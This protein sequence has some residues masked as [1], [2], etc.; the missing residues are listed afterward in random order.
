MRGAQSFSNTVADKQVAE[1]STGVDTGAGERAAAFGDSFDGNNSKLTDKSSQDLPLL[2]EK[3]DKADLDTKVKKQE[4]VLDEE[5]LSKENVEV[6]GSVNTN[7]FSNVNPESEVDEYDEES[8]ERLT[9]EECH[10]VSEEAIEFNTR[11]TDSTP[12]REVRETTVSRIVNNSS[13]DIFDELSDKVE[14]ACEVAVEHS[15]SLFNKALQCIGVGIQKINMRKVVK[16]AVI[17]KSGDFTFLKIGNNLM[18]YKYSGQRMDVE[19]PA[20]VG[21]IPVV[22]IHPDFFN[23]GHFG[24]GIL[25]SYQINAAKSMLRGDATESFLDFDLEELVKGLKSVKLPNTLKSI[26]DNVF[27]GCKNIRELVIPASVA[28]MTIASVKGSKVDT[29]Y[30]NGEIPSG[31]KVGDFHGSIY[32]KL[33]KENNNEKVS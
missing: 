19:I 13:G 16:N 17:V 12:R 20:Y 1:F 26:P 14:N 23:A 6:V 11:D 32:R 22:S 8:D 18:A 24:G 2:L 9:T 31:F 15:V 4:T 21:N 30:F 25:N 10:T 5:E 28:K 29:I 7:R 27:R 3:T 33:E